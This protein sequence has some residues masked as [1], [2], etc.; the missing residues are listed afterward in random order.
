MGFGFNGGRNMGTKVSASEKKKF[1]AALEAVDAAPAIDCEADRKRVALSLTVKLFGANPNRNIRA[2]LDEPA[3]QQVMAQYL[4][5]P[6][7]GWVH[8]DTDC[9]WV[10]VEPADLGE[11][12]RASDFAKLI[13]SHLVC[14]LG[15][16]GAGG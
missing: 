8:A 12:V 6:F 13:Y 11:V 9:N 10:H 2:Q 14:K 1:M 16:A 3:E 15:A 5:D 4:N 7:A